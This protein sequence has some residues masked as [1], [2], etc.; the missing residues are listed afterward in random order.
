MITVF[1][2]WL[3]VFFLCFVPGYY[4]MEA[5]DRRERRKEFRPDEYF[6]TGL[7]V[8]SVIVNLLSLVI[9]VGD[10]ALP[11]LAII[12]LILFLVKFRQMTV[13]H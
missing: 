12:G 3:L 9:A 13:V 8:I 11:V 10:Q 5:A 4:L 2:I 6:F 1:L 7:L